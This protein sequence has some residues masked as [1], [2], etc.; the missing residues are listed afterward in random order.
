MKSEYGVFVLK[1]KSDP[2]NFCIQSVRNWD[3]TRIA[4]KRG[5]LYI[6]RVLING[7]YS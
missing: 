7:V 6:I 5:F 4:D 3:W 1:R 2:L